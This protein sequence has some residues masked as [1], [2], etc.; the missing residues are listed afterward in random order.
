MLTACDRAGD[1]TR[2][3]AWLRNVEALSSSLNLASIP[4]LAHCWTAF[5]SVLCQVGRLREGET[6]LRMGLTKGDASFR[7]LRFATRAALADLWIRQGRLDEAAQL[8][9][10][11]IERVEILAPRARLYLAR[12]EYD[13]AAALARQALRHLVG[14]RFRSAPL[15][16]TVVEAE[17]QSGNLTAADEA[18][19]ELARLAD[20]CEGGF[21]AAHAALGLAKVGEARG[22]TASAIQQLEAALRTLQHGGS[23][24]L[25]AEVQLQL[26][27]LSRRD[28]PAAAAVAAET[29]LVL[30][31]MLG[32]PEADAAARLLRELGRQVPAPARVPT[33]LD[34]LS[35]RERE[36]LGCIA[37][38]LSNPEIATRLFITAKTAEHHVSSI[39]SKLGLKNR[40]EA[41]AFAASY[42][43]S[44]A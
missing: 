34:S 16:L 25:T 29:A 10:E 44:P 9:S 15:L 30:Y 1:V 22:A 20:G 18:A 41:A 31:R 42:S 35:P 28:H 43:I 23:A 11:N 12:R 40:T 36:V 39:L 27:R 7:H 8:L 14:D 21:V 5:G 3:Q 17:L 2:A 37:E 13:M 33:A 24:L 19:A 32:G 4:T 6:A 26:A 38:G